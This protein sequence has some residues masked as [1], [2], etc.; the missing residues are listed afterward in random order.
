MIFT[1]GLSYL[2]VSIFVSHK[3][4]WN[5]NVSGDFVTREEVYVMHV[6]FLIPPIHIKNSLKTLHL[7]I[8]TPKL[9]SEIDISENYFYGII[10][11]SVSFCVQICWRSINILISPMSYI[12]KIHGD[13]LFLGSRSYPRSW[14][15]SHQS[16]YNLTL[17]YDL[18]KFNFFFAS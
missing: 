2:A 17:N 1:V 8:F 7:H 10:L 18:K 3:I 9:P 11:V 12:I 6:I 14:P 13:N 5:S 16:H 4:S 15:L